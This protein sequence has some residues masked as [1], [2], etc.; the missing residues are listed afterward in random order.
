MLLPSTKVILF[1]I[2]LFIA[3]LRMEGFLETG[4]GTMK[5]QTKGEEMRTEAETNSEVK[6]A[7]TLLESLVN[8]IDFETA[9]AT[10]H[11]RKYENRVTE[12]QSTI[13]ST[14]RIKL[15]DKKALEE[16]T[17]V[18][19]LNEDRTEKYPDVISAQRVLKGDWP[20]ALKRAQV[21]LSE[22]N[23][24][25]M[26]EGHLVAYNEADG[27]IRAE[28][29]ERYRED[30]AAAYAEIDA[31]RIEIVQQFEALKEELVTRAADP[32]LH[33]ALDAWGRSPNT[34]G[35]WGED[36]KG[37][38]AGVTH[39][40]EYRCNK[41]KAGRFY[42]KDGTTKPKHELTLDA[43]IA[44]TKELDACIKE[45][46]PSQ[47][48]D[49]Q[50]STLIGDDAGQRRLMVFTSHRL[51]LNA[52]QRPGDRMRII[53]A[54]PQDEKSYDKAVE[55]E[56]NPKEAKRRLNALGDNRKKLPLEQYGT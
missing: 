21:Y 23:P 10:I 9:V 8:S 28:L 14:A 44:F 38:H 2:G 7:L 29:E 32:E 37:F 6:Q 5:P 17:A 42:G 16:Q 43:F 54:I 49:V 20:A 51:F 19:L 46:R 33:A 4:F 24:T 41:E 34:A 39:F 36:E 18:D 55:A 31:Q 27:K 12:I 3:T 30:K 53:T 35:E 22:M 50:K 47:N 56:V 52:F 11:V 45:P 15:K 1:W 25:L 48:P 13:E 26:V 40:F